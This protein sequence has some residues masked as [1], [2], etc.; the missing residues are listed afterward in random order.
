MKIGY[1]Y[2]GFKRRDLTTENLFDVSFIIFWKNK[3]R[4]FQFLIFFGKL[5]FVLKFFLLFI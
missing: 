5:K 2:G 1:A 3:G 4:K